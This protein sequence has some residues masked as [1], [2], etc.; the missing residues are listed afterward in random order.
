MS[1]RLVLFSH[2]LLNAI[3]YPR[4]VSDAGGRR[5][6]LEKLTMFHGIPPVKNNRIGYRKQAIILPSSNPASPIIG[7]INHAARIDPC[8]L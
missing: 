3:L 5:R 1:M 7:T 2:P 6:D 8:C 4:R